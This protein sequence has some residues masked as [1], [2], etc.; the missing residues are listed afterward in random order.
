MINQREVIPAEQVSRKKTSFFVLSL[1]VLFSVIANLPLFIPVSGHAGPISYI[2]R[3]HQ[4]IYST[5]ELPSE[6]TIKFNERPELGAS[7]IHVLASNGTRIDNN[8][9]KLGN[10]DNILTTSLNKSKI[11]PGIYF[12]KWIVLSKDDG[13]ITKNSYNFSY[14]PYDK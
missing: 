4:F 1:F 2:P 13:F 14:F 8:D 9:L 11:I 3:P 7:V 12:V 10:L 6:V 5:Q